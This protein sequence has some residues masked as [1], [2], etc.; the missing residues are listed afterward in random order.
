MGKKPRKAAYVVVKGRV[1][2][3]YT[4]WEKCQAQVNGFRGNEYKS[5]DTLRDAEKAW[6]SVSA[7]VNREVLGLLPLKSTNS[8]AGH[9][10]FRSE[11]TKTIK[12][13]SPG[14]E[15][16]FDRFGDIKRRKTGNSEEDELI[17]GFEYYQAPVLNS[18]KAEMNRGQVEPEEPLDSEEIPIVLT[19]A[20]QAVVDMAL[21]GDNIFLTGAAGSGKSVRFFLFFFLYIT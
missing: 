16:D 21:K 20:Q 11:N 4:E 2:G 18:P 12:R 14:D 7:L 13:P 9:G 17:Q 5:Y 19:T 15:N 3:V 6:A 1:P 10:L 8:R